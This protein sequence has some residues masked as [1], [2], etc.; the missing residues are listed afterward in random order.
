MEFRRAK[1]G[2]S[3]KPNHQSTKGPVLGLVLS[4][5]NGPPLFQ[6]THCSDLE[7]RLIDPGRLNMKNTSTQPEKQGKFGVIIDQK[8]VLSIT[9]RNF[10]NVLNKP[11]SPLVIILHTVC[12]TNDIFEGK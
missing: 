9:R 6:K 8:G 7:H 4:H 1:I 3:L 12:H 10:A 2:V 5:L 11:I